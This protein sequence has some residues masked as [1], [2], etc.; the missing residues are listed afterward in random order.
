M[1]FSTIDKDGRTASSNP[2]LDAYRYMAR[3][4]YDGRLTTL[5]VT[6]PAGEFKVESPGLMTLIFVP[7]NR[8]PDRS[9]G[10]DFAVEDE[11]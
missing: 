9:A 5:T 4:Q 3:L 2:K 6:E 11:Q 10:K 8:Y 7:A 1:Q